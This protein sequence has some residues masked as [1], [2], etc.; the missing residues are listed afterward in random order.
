MNPT[1]FHIN[2]RPEQLISTRKLD[3]SIQHACFLDSSDVVQMRQSTVQVK[4]SADVNTGA[5]QRQI[6]TFGIASF[7]IILRPK[8]TPHLLAIVNP[9]QYWIYQFWTLTTSNTVSSTTVPVV[10]Q[11]SLT[12]FPQ[13]QSSVP[14]VTT[15]TQVNNPTSHVLPNLSAWTFPA[16]S[17]FLTILA[18]VSH[19]VR[20]CYVNEPIVATRGNFVPVVPIQCGETSPFC[21]HLAI[22]ILNRTLLMSQSTTSPVKV[23]FRRFRLQFR[24]REFFSQ[25]QH[26]NCSAK[27]SAKKQQKTQEFVP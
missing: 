11:Q 1:A 4:S 13:V 6:P 18:T 14:L 22:L 7:L 2:H 5:D 9:L 20:G 27:T 15:L 24:Q 25:E 21:N 23:R 16:P 10:N 26:R 17:S 3:R 8:T 19:P 12:M